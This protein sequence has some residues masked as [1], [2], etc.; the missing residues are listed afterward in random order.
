[1]FGRKLK[2]LSENDLSNPIW[3]VDRHSD[4]WNYNLVVYRDF[5]S[6]DFIWHENPIIVTM[7]NNWTQDYCHFSTKANLTLPKYTSRFHVDFRKGIVR[8]GQGQCPVILW[9]PIWYYWQFSVDLYSN[10]ALSVKFLWECSGRVRLARLTRFMFGEILLMTS[11]VSQASFHTIQWCSGD[12]D[13]RQQLELLS[14][15]C[16]D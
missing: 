11:K 14:A 4:S 15:Q 12:A 10:G 8:P 2:L 5:H 3:A 7:S 9:S 13:N 16:Y 6:G 1:M